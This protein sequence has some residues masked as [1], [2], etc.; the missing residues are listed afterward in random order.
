M[1]HA[2]SFHGASGEYH[3][4]RDM[5]SNNG[6]LSLYGNEKIGWVIRDWG[7]WHVSWG[8]CTGEAQ[9]LIF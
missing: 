9:S 2:F 8:D 4:R 5:R 6:G 1:E 7:Q 3:G